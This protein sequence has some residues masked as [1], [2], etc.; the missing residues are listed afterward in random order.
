MWNATNVFIVL[1]I[2]YLALGASIGILI[3]IRSRKTKIPGNE[4]HQK[5][6]QSSKKTG[7]YTIN[8]HYQINSPYHKQG[9]M[10]TLWLASERTTEKEC[11]IKIPRRGTSLDSVY[12]DKL[13]AEAGY[14]KTLSHTNI[15]KYLDEYYYNDEFHLVLEYL[16]GQNLME[17]SPRISYAESQVINIASQ[18][19]SALSYIHTGGVVH[20]DVN[21]KNIILCTDGTVKL[22]DFGTAKD[23]NGVTKSPGK[24]DPFTKIANK[25]FD[26]PEVFTGGDTDGRCD[27]CGLA[28]TCIYLL[29]LEQPNEICL[30]L[31]GFSWPRTYEEARTVVDYM[32]D[33]NVSNRTAKCL[34][35]GILY[36]AN[37]RFADANAMKAALLS[38]EGYPVPPVEA[39]AN[40]K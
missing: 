7:I 2:I 31:F 10:A 1:V 39:Q 29:T 40:K 24:H 4:Q 37:R 36:S 35:Q 16:N 13:L 21:P 9:G 30:N 18:L 34:A 3:N 25:G 33:K 19:L 27:L 6:A 20:R 8:E 26:I 5:Q 32:A 14:L 11:I 17:A 23:I 22:I 12:L 28:Q 15:I 38:A